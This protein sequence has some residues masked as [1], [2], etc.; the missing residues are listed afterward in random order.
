MKFEFMAVH[1]PLV[2]VSVVV[3]AGNTVHSTPDCCLIP[4]NQ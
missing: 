4:D 1:R 3:A 2:S